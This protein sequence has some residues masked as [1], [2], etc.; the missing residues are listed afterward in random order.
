MISVLELTQSKSEIAIEPTHN[1][2]EGLGEHT[3][4]ASV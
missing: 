4:I 1:D 2:N 3:C